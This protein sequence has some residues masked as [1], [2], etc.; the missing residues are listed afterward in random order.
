MFS[1]NQTEWFPLQASQVL[2][3]PLDN[4]NALSATFWYKQAEKVKYR[5]E[6]VPVATDVYGNILKNADGSYKTVENDDGSVKLLGSYEADSNVSLVEVSYKHFDGY[7]VLDDA[8]HISKT[9]VWAQAD[10]VAAENTIT[11]Y[12]V[13]SA[14]SVEY[15]VEY[16]VQDAQGSYSLDA[17]EKREGHAGET[18]SLDVSNNLKSYA[19]LRFDASAKG[20]KLSGTVSDDLVLRVYYSRMKVNVSVSWEDEADPSHTVTLS[21]YSVSAQKKGTLDQFYVLEGTDMAV[22]YLCYPESGG[23]VVIEQ[24]LPEGTTAETQYFTDGIDSASDFFVQGNARAGGLV[25]G[26]SSVLIKNYEKVLLPSTGWSPLNF[27]LKTR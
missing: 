25:S 2:H 3:V 14:S 11:F 9:L 22:F 10:T 4:T 19:G 24:S 27:L 26:S 1:L 7:H 20:A 18:V 15:D 17:V 16:Y 21:A 23:T 13:E 6:Y 8:Y 12:Y 5:V